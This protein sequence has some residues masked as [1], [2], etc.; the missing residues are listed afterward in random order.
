M[1]GRWAPDRLLLR[2]RSLQ[3][4]RRPRQA[5]ADQQPARAGLADGRI[6]PPPLRRRLAPRS[7]AVEQP[8]VTSVRLQ[9]PAARTRTGRGAWK[10]GR[11]LAACRS[12]A[13]ASATHTVA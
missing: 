6:R 8:A 11:A 4:P 1:S 5:T 7:V 2:G 12:P 9:M 3:P 13:G 10:T